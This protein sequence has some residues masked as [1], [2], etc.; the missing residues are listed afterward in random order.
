[1][2]I[3]NRY[4][5]LRYKNARTRFVNIQLGKIVYMLFILD[6]LNS[7]QMDDEDYFLKTIIPSRKANKGIEE[8]RDE[9][10]SG[11]IGG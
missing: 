7:S 2:V 10:A 6:L 4:I 11:Y 8:K 1:M 3:I 9:Y 5:Q